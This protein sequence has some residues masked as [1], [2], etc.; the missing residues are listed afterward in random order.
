MK[1]TNIRFLLGL[2]VML[3][4]IFIVMQASDMNPFLRIKEYQIWLNTNYYTDK[5]NFNIGIILLT[6]IIG[7]IV[8]LWGYSLSFNEIYK[9]RLPLIKGNQEKENFYAQLK[10][11]ELEILCETFYL[12]G[13][14]DEKTRGVEGK[15]SHNF[16][17]RWDEWKRDNPNY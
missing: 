2:I 4:G 1:K 17:K 13:N 8:I 15:P 7:G 14:T 6:Y 3:V 11:K 5:N 12:M 9:K 16:E 10:Q